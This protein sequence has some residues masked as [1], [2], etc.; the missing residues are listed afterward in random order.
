MELLCPHCSKQIQDGLPFGAGTVMCPHC[1][2]PFNVPLSLAVAIEAEPGP[3]PLPSASPP[4]I[5][6]AATIELLPDSPEREPF[7]TS[8]RAISNSLWQRVKVANQIIARYATSARIAIMTLPRCYRALGKQAFKDG[9]FRDEFAS[10][11]GSIDGLLA[12]VAAIQART[13]ERLADKKAANKP[14]TRY[15]RS[16]E[17]TPDEP[18][19]KLT[20]NMPLGESRRRLGII[21]QRNPGLGC[22]GIIGAF[23]FLCWSCTVLLPRPTA[24]QEHADYI[25]MK[26][27]QADEEEGEAARKL[28]DALEVEQYRQSH[29]R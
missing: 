20:G 27:R 7:A 11:F 18:D 26:A 23:L 22:L 28:L 15:E 12:E 16:G 19:P 4:P 5:P 17:T 29:Q 6:P 25:R 13:E 2:Q 3:P 21:L 10:T 24:E 8:A 14:M 9:K 1:Q